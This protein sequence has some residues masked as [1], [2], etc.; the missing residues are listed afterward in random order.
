VDLIDAICAERLPDHLTKEV[1]GAR[2]KV[3][4]QEA[5]E[6]REERKRQRIVSDAI[7]RLADLDAQKRDELVAEVEEQLGEYRFDAH[8]LRARARE[9]NDADAAQVDEQTADEQQQKAA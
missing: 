9:L 5:R 8:E 3:R 7:K 6:R 1:R 2:A 4:K